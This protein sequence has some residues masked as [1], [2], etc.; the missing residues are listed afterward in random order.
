MA[1]LARDQGES[2]HEGAADAE[3]V[4]VHARCYGPSGNRL[5]RTLT[6]IQ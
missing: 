6:E 2:G 5:L 3:K 1:E 4:D